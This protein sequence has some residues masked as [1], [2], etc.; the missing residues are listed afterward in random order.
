MS[1]NSSA[2]MGKNR[3]GIAMSPINAKA[4]AEGAKESPPSSSGDRHTQDALK[5]SYLEQN[6]R[7]G[8]VP[9]P[10][11]LKGVAK[12]ALKMIQGEKAT[13]LV[14]KLAERLAF[15][16]TGTRLYEAII[17]KA[18]VLAEQSGPR[19]DELEKIHHE[20]LSHFHMVKGYLENLGGDPTA[21]TPSADVVGVASSGLL[22][23][24]TDP[25]TTMPQSL[26]ALL[27]AELA[28]N[29]GWS[30]LIKLAEGFNQDQMAADFRKALEAEERH[31]M[32]VRGWLSART[33][34]EAGAA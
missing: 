29:D 10:A 28:D 15:E 16:R 17:G 19:V 3:T 26:Q 5:A 30:T 25:R 11:N 4:V 31:L 34:E 23:V 13:V 33:Q 12:T 27:I 1:H 2:E 32:Q 6:E 8:S 21:Q 18:E 7:I 24:I 20:E 14:D 9:P 22:K